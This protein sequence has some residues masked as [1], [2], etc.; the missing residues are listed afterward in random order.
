MARC[1]STSVALT[2]ELITEE[3]QIAG[4]NERF[5]MSLVSTVIRFKLHFIP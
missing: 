5:Q 1:Q 2:G 3:I 4:M